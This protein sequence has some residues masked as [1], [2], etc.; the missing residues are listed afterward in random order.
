MW[1]HPQT[2]QSPGAFK[3]E[4]GIL[5]VWHPLG[6]LSYT[7]HLAIYIKREARRRVSNL[8]VFKEYHRN[9]HLG[10][11]LAFGG[12]I[13]FSLVQEVKGQVVER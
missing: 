10:T 2:H 3:A 4:S 8:H 7:L 1:M 6:L 5:T 9:F 11:E 13:V 12:F